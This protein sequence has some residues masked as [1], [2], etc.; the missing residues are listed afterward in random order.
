MLETPFSPEAELGKDKG[1]D[2][3]I[4][5]FSRKTH[6]TGPLEIYY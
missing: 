6:M 4:W 2:E 5:K 3:I 1:T